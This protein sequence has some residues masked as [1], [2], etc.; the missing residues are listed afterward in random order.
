MSD[1]VFADSIMILHICWIIFMIWGFVLTVRGFWRPAFFDR[2]LFRSIHLAGIMFVAG[3]ELVGRYCPLTIWEYD[4]RRSY[5][6]SIEYPRLFVV[7]FIQ[8]LI[9]PDVSMLVL[10]I[11]TVAIALFTMVVFILR[12][13][14]KCK[15]GAPMQHS[16]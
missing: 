5:D 6:P 9:Y 16:P 13:P 4:F 3:L 11:P 10:T 7:D 2:W 12:P 15:R 14:S 1:R 8:R